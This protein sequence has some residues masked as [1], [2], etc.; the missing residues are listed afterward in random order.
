MSK[1]TSI[2]VYRGP[3]ML[4]GH[5]HEMVRG[6]L[7]F[8][9]DN[10][11]TGPMAQLWILPDW[12][13]PISASAFGEDGAICGERPQRRSL[14]G[15]C[16]VTI[17]Q[18]PQSAWK[19]SNGKPVDVRGAY[20]YL[21]RLGRRMGG[22]VLRLGAY[23]DPAALPESLIRTLVTAVDGRTT[24]YTHQ[25]REASWIRPYVM[26]SVESIRDALIARSSGWR[27]FRVTAG[28]ASVGRGELVCLA[29]SK[30][31]T[32]QEC[33]LCDGSGKDGRRARVASI[34]IPAHGSLSNRAASAC[35]A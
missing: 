12:Q 2:V 24:G 15:G 35:E 6:V 23:G 26:A 22:A 7:S 9:S 20:A 4:K 18:G 25:W 32:C 19:G 16:Y 10:V 8:G 30:G 31:M 5:G 27:T 13:S 33:G 1:P 28:D 29:E 11:K 14:G 17:F 21:R 3:S 34:V